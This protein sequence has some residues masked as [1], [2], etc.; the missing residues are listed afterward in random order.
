MPEQVFEKNIFYC[1]PT[2]RVLYYIIVEYST[3]CQGTALQQK[4]KLFTSNS[5]SVVTYI[6][7]TNI[8]NNIIKQYYCIIKTFKVLVIDR[9]SLAE[10]IFLFRIGLSRSMSKLSLISRLY[11]LCPYGMMLNSSMDRVSLQFRRWS[12][13]ALSFDILNFLNFKDD[14]PICSPD[15][16]FKCLFVSFY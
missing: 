10:L 15:L 8:S 2:F 12:R 5:K 16:I 6:T 7:I 4:I 14:I 1:F 13:I 9:N 11:F 3:H